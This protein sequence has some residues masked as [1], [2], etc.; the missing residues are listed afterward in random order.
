MAIEAP[1]SFTIP[2]LF[3]GQTTVIE[4]EKVDGASAYILQ[5]KI[6]SSASYSTIYTGETSSYSDTVPI[7]AAS[8]WYRVCAV[9]SDSSTSDWLESGQQ[10]TYT[11]PSLPKSI[12][13][14]SSVTAGDTITVTWTAPSTTAHDGYEL[15]RS[16]GTSS[17]TQ[18]YKGTAL[19][20]S[21]KALDA[22]TTVSYRIRTYKT[23][24]GADYYPS[25]WLSGANSVT[26]NAKG[27]TETIDAPASITVP[28]LVAGEDATITWSTVSN[29]AKYDLSSSV[30]GGTSYLIY[31]GATTS[32]T[33]AIG[34]AWSTV[35]YRVRAYASSG[36]YSDETSSGTVTVTK[37]GG[38]ETIDAPSSITVPTLTA[39]ET[40]TISWTAVSNASTYALTCYVNGA[41]SGTVKY[42]GSATSCQLAVDSSWTTVKFGVRAYTSSGTAS[43]ET[44]SESVAVVQPVETISAPSSI[45]VPELTSGKS[46]TITWSTTS[47]AAGYA[48]QRAVNGGSFTTLY[49][50]ESASYTDTV[51]SSWT[52]AQYQVCA[53]TSSGTT[54]EYTVSDVIT[55]TQPTVETDML[56]AIRN[57]AEQTIKI[58]FADGTILG[59]SDVAVADGGVT[60]TDVL[61][62]DEDYTFGKAVCKQVEMTLFNTDG[63][64][65]SFDFT[66]EFTLQIG[67]KCGEDF[68]YVTLG[69]FVGERPDKVRGKQIEFTAYDRMSLFDT[70]ASDFIEGLTFPT[71]LADILTSLCTTVSVELATTSFTNSAKSFAYN[72]FSTSDYT[73]REVLAWIAE[74]AGCYARINV[75]G[76]VELMTFAT[77]EHKILKT[78]RFEMSESEFDVPVVGKIECYTSYSDQLVISGEGASTYVISD[79]PFLY[80]ENTDD[81]TALQ[82]YVDAIYNKVSTFPAYAPISVRAEWYP[83]INCGDIITIVDD[84]GDEMTLP[85]FSQTITWAGYGKVEYESTGG[86]KREVESIE[87]REL[88]SIKKKMLR[89]SDLSTEIESYL[90][91]QEGIASI[92]SA[93]E[94]E[95]VE[96]SNGSTIT[97]TSAIEQLI[98]DTKSGIESKISLTAGVGKGTIGSNVQALLTLFA[99]TD[100]SSISLSANALDLTATETTGST[101]T[102]SAGTYSDTPWYAGSDIPVSPEYTFSQ[103]SDGYYTSQNAGV[104]SSY[105]LGGFVFNFAIATTITIR[106]ISYGEATC[107]YGI[108]SALDTT[109]SSANELDSSGVLYA[110]SASS[111]TSATYKD[112]TLTVPRGRHYITCKYIKDGSVN[113]N[114]DYFKIKC[115]KTTTSRGKAT[116]TLKSGSINL[117]STD[118]NFNGLVTFTDLSTAGAT[119]IDGGNVTTDNLFVENVYFKS[120]TDYTIVTSEMSGENGIVR[121]GVQEPI[122]DMAAMLE[123]YGSFIYFMNPSSSATKYSLQVQTA[124]QAVIPG[125]TGWTIGSVNNPFDKLY[126]ETIYYTTQRDL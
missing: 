65:N 98:R 23:I 83:E 17:Y 87:Q 45:T 10:T 42:N 117:S 12:T 51:Q 75:N 5:R 124:N 74:A 120:N 6:T 76:K 79:N 111:D 22:W 103:T 41:S 94:G 116:L 108:V 125:G 107:D 70:S 1:K 38:V 37:S 16:V 92:K 118:I 49:R 86:R 115:F 59:K 63:K 48:L 52:T 61:N 3:K 91:T 110:F 24:N 126:V 30:D 106:C 33:D 18:V 101:S 85:I 32:Y 14:P 34:E 25:G 82:T 104:A 28:T 121:V 68:T 56:T 4:W 20:F 105:A 97:S 27:E 35:E 44:L 8:V 96:V 39:G 109:L 73:A 123:L 40:A 114:G 53:Y 15:Q 47:N 13:V 93:V 57:H 36:V 90:N 113:K 122:S 9:S 72:P 81:S 31:S 29:A 89:S 112:L 21:E 58:T 26:V 100:S 11:V 62:G 46:V 80:S 69:T 67:V 43:E 71:T 119:T 78:D 66:Q 7:K 95:F 77:K 64:F 60:I 19:T 55:V 99:N 102:E 84:Y 54:S 88:E 2:A 50:G